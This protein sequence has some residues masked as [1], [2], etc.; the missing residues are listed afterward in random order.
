MKLRHAFLAASVLVAVSLSMPAPAEAG[1]KGAELWQRLNR[2]EKIAFILGAT[3]GHQ[4]SHL[5]I[6]DLLKARQGGVTNAE[7]KTLLAGLETKMKGIS[8]NT[9][10]LIKGL[11][12]FYS[13]EKNAQINP[14]DAFT[15]MMLHLERN[16]RAAAYLARLRK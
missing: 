1:G 3:G 8:R 7:L 11:D 12:G 16:P 2:S 4:A 5:H 15:Y 6:A 10:A 14:R 13:D 9:A